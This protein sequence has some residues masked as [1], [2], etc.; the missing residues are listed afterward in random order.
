MAT[1][2]HYVSL[3]CLVTVILALGVPSYT[4]E[5][6]EYLSSVHQSLVEIQRTD[7]ESDID[8]VERLARIVEEHCR[9]FT[10]LLAIIMAAHA[11]QP[12]HVV[13]YFWVI[14][15]QLGAPYDMDFLFSY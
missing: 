6:E 3:P 14:P 5:L 12:A 7:I 13:S 4:F 8:A 1:V 11:G 15:A 2:Y 9:V 10:A